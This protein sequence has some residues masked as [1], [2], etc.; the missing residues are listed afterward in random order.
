VVRLLLQNDADPNAVDA[1]GETP[2]HVACR[3]NQ[4]AA[5]HEL[6]QWGACRVDAVDMAGRNALH[7]AAFGNSV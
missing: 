6:T 5:V 2:F 7:H 3:H 1:R 4:L